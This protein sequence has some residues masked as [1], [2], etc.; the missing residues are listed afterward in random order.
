MNVLYLTVSSIGN[1]FHQDKPN[2]QRVGQRFY[3]YFKLER[4]TEPSLKVLCDKVYEATT[5]KEIRALLVAHTDY[6]H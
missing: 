6:L 3:D 4:I 2:A 1:F 5:D